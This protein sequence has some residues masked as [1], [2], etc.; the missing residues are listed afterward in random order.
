MQATATLIIMRSP[1]ECMRIAGF[2]PLRGGG[3]CVY[4]TNAARA[5]IAGDNVKFGFVV[6]EESIALTNGGSG[7][8]S[9]TL[10]FLD[11]LNKLYGSEG[12]MPRV[13]A[14]TER[15]HQDGRFA[16]AYPGCITHHKM[17]VLGGS[18]QLD[19]S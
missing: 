15:F 1:D 3:A 18:V 13:F 19:L 12:Y 9:E 17:D 6:I 11:E 10:R 2:V 7:S 14:L 5:Q 4:S 8:A 16:K